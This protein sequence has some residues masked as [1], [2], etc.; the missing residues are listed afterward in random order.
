MSE[1]ERERERERWDYGS[2]SDRLSGG[3]LVRKDLDSSCEY[4]A[5]SV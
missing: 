3:I 4:S 2:V 1:R 5:S